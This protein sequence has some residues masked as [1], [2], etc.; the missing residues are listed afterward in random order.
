[1]TKTTHEKIYDT[2]MLAI[3]RSADTKNLG[4][5]EVINK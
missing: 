3:G 1:M 2:V 4:A 5:R